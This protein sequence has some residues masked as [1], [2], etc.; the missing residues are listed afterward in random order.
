M[1]AIAVAEAP[2]VQAADAGGHE[3]PHHTHCEN[4]GAALHGPWCHACGQH[5]FE[6]HRSFRHVALEALESFFHFDGSFF[7][8]TLT[9]L[10]KPGRLTERF[11][12]GKRAAQ[13]PPFRLYVFV[14]F[15]FFLVMHVVGIDGVE[16]EMSGIASPAEPDAS[17]AAGAAGAGVPAGSAV[18]VELEDAP[19][20]AQDLAA[21]AS[22]PEERRRLGER[23]LSSI[24]K[25][26]LV[27]LPVFALLTRLLYRRAPEWVYLKHLVLALH[28]HTFIYLWTLVVAA[29]G[30]VAALPGWG[31]ES[32]VDW[33]GNLWLVAYPPLML[34]HL[35]RDSWPRTVMKTLLLSVGYSA[36]LIAAFGVAGA[37]VLVF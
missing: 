14:A 34:R 10:F 26:M 2:C 22:D 28:Y 19:P 23:F 7:R 31:V 9:L 15:V 36:V 37:I 35:F 13:M 33:V 17:V 18:R 16:V 24:P 6:F 25:V 30:W 3:R 29:L 21:R 12:A 32:V 11:H 20:W 27:C 5:D 4:C 8:S 1:D